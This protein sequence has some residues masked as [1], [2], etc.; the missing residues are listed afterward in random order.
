M[1]ALNYR[2]AEKEGNGSLAAGLLA[3]HVLSAWP[4]LSQHLS[5][6]ICRT[7]LLNYIEF[8]DILIL[9]L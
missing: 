9:E 1:M 8:G 3:I 2:A 4:T 6:E 7:T 5:F